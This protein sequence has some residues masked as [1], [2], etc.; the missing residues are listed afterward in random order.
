MSDISLSNKFK[1]I[2]IEQANRLPDSVSLC[3]SGGVDSVALLFALQEVGKEISV[4]SFTLDSFESYDYRV[5]KQLAEFFNLRFVGVKLST[6]VAELKED[7]KVLHDVLKCEKKTEYECVWPFMYLYNKVTEKVVVTGLGAEGH[8]GTTKTGAIHFRDNLDSFREQFFN[9]SNV[10]EIVQHTMLAEKYL[11][12]LWF[13][14]LTEEVISCFKRSEWDDI[15]KPHLK[16]TILDAFSDKF[17]SLPVKLRSSNLQIG[18]GISKHFEKL[19]ATDWNINN[20]K[21]TVGI[22][23]SVNRGVYNEKRKLI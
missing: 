21:S 11:K 18:S 23:N 22:F 19:L 3:L 9:N 2:L 6:N 15:N 12:T 10:S 13:P 1:S 5:A 8:F 4:Y 20:Y 17:N 14:F 16:Q 7:I